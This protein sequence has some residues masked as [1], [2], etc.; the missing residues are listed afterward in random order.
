MSSRALYRRFKNG[1]LEVEL[2]PIKGKKKNSS[3]EKRGK[4]ALK[5]ST[6]DRKNTTLTLPLNLV[7]LSEIP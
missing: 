3:V 1:T 6:H 7:T 5:R 2:L 4:Q